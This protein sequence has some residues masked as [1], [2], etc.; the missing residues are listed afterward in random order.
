MYW[1]KQRK[2]WLEQAEKKWK[3]QKGQMLLFD[4]K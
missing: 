1:I 3:K 4:E 2:E